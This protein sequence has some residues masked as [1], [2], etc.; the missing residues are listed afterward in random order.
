MTDERKEKKNQPGS[1]NPGKANS[2]QRLIVFGAI[3]MEFLLQILLGPWGLNI[4]VLV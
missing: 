1:K 2:P 4:E 3:L